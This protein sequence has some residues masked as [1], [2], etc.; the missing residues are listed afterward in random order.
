MLVKNNKVRIHVSKHSIYSK[1]V[2]EVI[3]EF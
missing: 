3:S 2:G 1:Y